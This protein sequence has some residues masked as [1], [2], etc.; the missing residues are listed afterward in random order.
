MSNNNLYELENLLFKALELM[1][2]NLDKNDFNDI[3]EY[4]KFG[5]YGVAYDLFI[6][7]LDKL[8]ISYP[9]ELKL[10]GNLMNLN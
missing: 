3:D 4:I 7:A 8:K 9:D 1:K 6:F 2:S 10:A 5:E